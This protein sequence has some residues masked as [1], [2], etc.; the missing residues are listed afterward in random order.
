M[1]SRP[2]LAYRWPFDMHLRDQRAGGVDHRQPAGAS[3]FFDRAGDAM[4]TEDRDAAGRDLV[5]LVD[6]MRSFGAQT[7]DNVTVMDDLMTDVNRGPIF[8][9]RSFDDLD[10]P[11]DPGAKASWLS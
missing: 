6:E 2:W 11:F 1:I 9:E 4:R 10:C 3:A 7:I 5:N 8:F